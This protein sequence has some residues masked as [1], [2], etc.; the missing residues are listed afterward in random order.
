[1]PRKSSANIA[2]N[3]L[4]GVQRS[5]DKV[6][7]GVDAVQTAPGELAAQAEDRWAEG[8]RKAK[9]SG[10]FRANA[11]SVSLGTWKDKMKKKGIPRMS[12]GASQA[13]SLVQAFHDQHQPVAEASADAAASERANGVDGRTRMLNNYDRMA[14]FKFV[15]PR[16]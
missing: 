3:W 14:A 15:R 5:G 1:M 8:V 11:A 10:K 4:A 9:E 12:D 2:N 16:S 6:S 13:K 7:Q